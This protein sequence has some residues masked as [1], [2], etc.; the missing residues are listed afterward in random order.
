MRVQMSMISK[1][2]CSNWPIKHSI[3][4]NEYFFNNNDII[5]QLRVKS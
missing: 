3:A 5:V 1:S 4:K 2:Y